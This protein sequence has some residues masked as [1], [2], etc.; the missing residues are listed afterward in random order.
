[1]ISAMPAWIIAMPETTASIPEM[2]TRLTVTA[3]TVSGIP[4]IRAAMRVTLR[5]STG[6]MQQPKRTSSMSAGSIPALLTAS[7]ITTLPS[8][9]QF[10]SRSE[11][12]KVPMAVRQA[13][14]ITH[15]FI[16]F[17]PCSTDVR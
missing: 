15:S 17:P 16:R 10:R 3:V 9:A 12:P 5:A 2:Q 14:T 7:R 8:A 1:M 11:P 4:A 13:D 6:S